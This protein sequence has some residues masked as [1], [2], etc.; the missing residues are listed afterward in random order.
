[1]RIDE[2]LSVAELS[3]LLPGH[4][5]DL[6]H[7]IWLVTGGRR[8]P[9]LRLAGEFVPGAGDP[10]AELALSVPSR[11]G[12]L[13]PDV[14]L[15]R[16]LETAAERSLP[17]AVRARVLIRL[18]RELLGDP[19]AV[20]RRRTLVDEA[21]AL[22]RADG[23]G[24]ALARAL[25]GRLHALWDPAGATDRL[26]TAAEIIGLACRAGDP[27]TE[28]SG[29]LWRFTALTELGDL[30][31]AETALVT[32]GRAGELLGDVPAKVIVLSRQAVFEAAR[33]RLAAAD[34]LTDQAEEAGHRAGIS[35][36]NRLTAGLRGQ[37]A[38]LRGQPGPPIE[39]LREMART[40]P[41][42]FFGAT[43]ARVLLAAGRD[44]EALLELDRVLP[45]VLAGTGPRWLGAVADLA[46]V[47]AHGGTEQ[48]AHL[49]YAALVPYRGRL[50][51]GGFASTVTGTVDAL[52]GRLAHRLGRRDEALG[53]FD[54]AVAQEERLGTLAWL[55]ATLAARGRPGDTE[56]ARSLAGRLGIT[57]GEPG[58]DEWRLLRAGAGDDWTLETGD[59]TVRLR[60]VRGLHFLR[61][62][63][64][65]P[66]REIAALDL[67]AGGAGLRTAPAEPL[68]D[69]TARDTYRRR[70][71]ELDA[72]LDEA[73]RTGDVTV[74]GTVTRE[75]SALV[76]QLR[77]AA[78]GA[79]RPRRHGAE[80][81]R[82]RV[83]A[84]RALSTVLGRLDTAAPIVALH[85]RAS[86][87]TGAV[88]RYQPAP[89]GPARW[90]V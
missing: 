52:L 15:V 30:E 61:T 71:S 58:G 28:L 64:A 14:A 33:G 37:L 2:P 17:V 20:E 43:V 82:A 9:A 63:L 47:A 36:T 87:R 7:A 62:L 29:M 50:V 22:A 49:L 79:G 13:I 67:V 11:S 65:A 46:V 23:D 35:D 74:A 26:D 45:A 19:A 27:E 39:P 54:R 34:S 76:A 5:R 12:F 3:V 72:R 55:A 83:N 53:H 42:Q 41:G 77:A 57:I 32:Y 59:T 73:D 56:R 21:V 24:R 90:R 25:D 69:S 38:L 44:D 8:G 86:L 4:D 85:L 66:G 80:A 88:L 89:G 48:T 16:L 1:M 75:R 84:T 31:A 70:L 60:D 78:G 10:V 68:L 40:V 18:A 6:V 51:V 81:E